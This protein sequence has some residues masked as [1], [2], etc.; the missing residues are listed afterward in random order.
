METVLDRNLDALQLETSRV[1][2]EFGPGQ[3][4]GKFGDV[5]TVRRFYHLLLM[6]CAER[7]T[8]MD[9]AQCVSVAREQ[10]RRPA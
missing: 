5:D 10:M 2:Q 8:A 6:E 3:N 1:F 9:F 4:V 7:M